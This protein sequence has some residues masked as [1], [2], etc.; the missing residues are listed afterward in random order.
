VSR[1][2]LPHAIRALAEAQTANRQEQAKNKPQDALPVA[3]RQSERDWQ[4]TV[5]QYAALRG[6]R[7]FHDNATNAPRRCSGCG[8]I[9]HL[10]R[11]APGWPDLVLVRRPDVLFVELKSDAGK[12]D[13]D[14]QR[15]IDDLRACGQRVYVWRPRDWDDVQRVLDGRA[16]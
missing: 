9:R 10:P 11:N 7:A 8:A 3:F 5:L 13:H 16:S 14:Q 12:V 6:W 1:P 4:A 15:W 2:R